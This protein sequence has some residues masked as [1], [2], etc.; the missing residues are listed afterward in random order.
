L[1][2][3]K[4]QAS[5]IEK[6]LDPEQTDLRKKCRKMTDHFDQLVEEVRRLARDLSPTM[7]KDL[8]LSSALRRLIEDF[9]HHSG[10]SNNINQ[11]QNI[12]DLFSLETQIGIYRIFQESL[13]N[14]GKY[15]QASQLTVAIR[16]G[17]GHVSFLVSDN[18]RG[19]NVDEVW[20]RDPASR[21]LGLMAMEE[22]A[23]MMGGSLEIRSQEGQGTQITFKIP[24][25]GSLAG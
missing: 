10:V 1:L 23:R 18:G 21:G 20:G 15:A 25:S 7:V 6:K 14:I 13:T 5:H 2:V 3:L 22:R 24:V 4:L 11:I 9:G 16:R 19:F 12:D 8:G 17:D